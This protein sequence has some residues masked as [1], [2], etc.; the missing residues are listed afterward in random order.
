MT[1]RYLHVRGHGHGHHP[2]HSRDL[3]SDAEGHNP[4]EAS[5]VIGDHGTG[6]ANAIGRI[7]ARENNLDEKPVGSTMTIPIILGIW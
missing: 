2:L 3:P 4:L 5:G 1:G 6:D 7:T